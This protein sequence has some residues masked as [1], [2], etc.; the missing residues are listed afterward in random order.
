[1]RHRHR[2]ERWLHARISETLEDALKREAR[3]RRQPVSLLVRNVLEG[4][5]DLVEDIVESSLGVANGFEHHGRHDPRPKPPTADGS[6]LSDV[7]GW[8]EIILNRAASC[9]QCETGLGGGA[10]AFRGLRDDAGPAIFLC[11]AC[12]RRLRHAAG[13]EEESR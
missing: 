6:G 12:I 7:Y 10:P 11:A 13:R 4:A 1:V 8:Q 3:R 2:Q 5:L 9:A